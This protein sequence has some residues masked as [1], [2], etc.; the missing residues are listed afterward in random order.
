MKHFALALAFA[1][2]PCMAQEKPKA[3]LVGHGDC[4][5]YFLADRYILRPDPPLSTLARMTDAEKEQ[6]RK[7]SVWHFEGLTKAEE[8][9]WAKHDHK[10]YPGLC[11]IPP[12]FFKNPN[13]AALPDPSPR[14]LYYALYFTEKH[15]SHGEVATAAETSTKDVPIEAPATVYDSHGQNVGT[16][17]V[18]GTATVETTTRY[19]VDVTVYDDYVQAEVRRVNAD[20]SSAQLFSTFRARSLGRGGLRELFARDPHAKTLDECLRFLE[21]EAGLKEK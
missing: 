6:W 21:R 7:Q 13:R 16:A 19:P 17:T 20:G 11:Y 4:R 15:S 8:D 12:L 14:P 3:G 1:A 2:L 18:T 10:K 9:W 5:I